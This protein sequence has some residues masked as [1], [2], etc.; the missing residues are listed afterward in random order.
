MDPI[1]LL[2]GTQS[3]AFDRAIQTAPQL[4]CSMFPNKKILI[5]YEEVNL[6]R[7]QVWSVINAVLQAKVIS[8]D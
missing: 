4:G 2:T 6:I 8:Y 3:N 1:L 7:E 5:F